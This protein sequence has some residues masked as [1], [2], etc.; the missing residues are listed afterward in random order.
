MLESQVAEPPARTS[1]NPAQDGAIDVLDILLV[2][3]RDR[4]RIAI[5]TLVFFLLGV[6]LAFIL[7]PT[8]TA[9]ATLLPPQHEQS[10]LSAVL[11]QVA[12]GSL[13]GLGGAS[14]L[15]KNPADIYV[16]MIKSRTASDQV[17]DRFHLKAV[18]KTKSMV[19][20]YKALNSHVSVDATKDGLIEIKVKDHDPRR[21]SDIANGLVDALYHLTSSLA[22]TEAAQRRRFFHQQMDNE[23]T[24]LAAAEQKLKA[25]QEKTGLIQLSDQ[26]AVIIRSIA[27]LRAEIVNREVELQAARSYATE[28]NP[29]VIRLQQQIDS[30]QKQ[31]AAMESNHEQ[32]KPGNIQ[33]PIVQVPQSSM[34]YA[35]SL[36]DVTFHTKLLALIAKEYEAA[37]IDEAKSAPLIQVVDHAVPPDKKSGPPRLLIIVGLA[38]FGFCVG[39]VWA[40]LK[41]SIE[42]IQATPESAA[43]LH[44][45]RSAIRLRAR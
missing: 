26:A 24:A 43:K 21:A 10:S 36:R 17:I 8:F 41:R 39:C 20:T 19:D 7:R 14:G 44:Q 34:E 35:N 23:N 27:N 5:V 32:M 16:A 2:V 1:L 38:F 15:L 28:E 29:D 45:L 31:L 37:R 6:L 30:L 25:T 3:A 42:R 22:I 40:F 11:G 4:R 9:S 13:T 12:I 18:Y 33:V